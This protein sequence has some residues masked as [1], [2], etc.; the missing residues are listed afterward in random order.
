MHPHY[1]DRQGLLA[2]WR[3]ALLAQAVLADPARGYGR[4]PQLD[5]F[6]AHG[7]PARAIAAFLE[8]IA[9]EAGERGYR[10]DATKIRCA[11]AG[12]E[13]IDLT[14]GQLDYEWTHLRAKLGSRSPDVAARWARLDRP[15]PHPLF[16]LVPGPLASWERPG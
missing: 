15:D 13:P 7:E 6:K 8:A 4:H 14:E 2:G 9:A 10:F 11:G 12:C 3:E 1:L 16:R 5:R